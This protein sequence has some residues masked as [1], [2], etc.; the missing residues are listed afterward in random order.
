MK[1]K[2][3]ADLLLIFITIVWGFSIPLMRNTLS[4]IPNQTY[5]FYRFL[6]A[7]IIL[8]VIFR[9]K[10][11]KVSKLSIIR[12][13]IVGIFLAGT[14]LLTVYALSYTTASNVSFISGL[15]I[16]TVPVL[17][18]IFLKQRLNIRGL[19]GIFLA[20]FGLFL[21]SGGF[22]LSFNFGDFLA[23]LCAIFLTLQILFIDIYGKSEDPFVLG[24]IQI[25]TA[26]GIYFLVLCVSG[27]SY[28]FERGGLVLFTIILTGVI[29]TALAFVGQTY[30]QQFTSPLHVAIIFIL[31]PV[32]GAVFSSLLPNSQGIYEVLGKEEIIGGFVL[33]I[34][35]LIVV[36]DLNHSS[37]SKT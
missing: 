6:L 29:S 27:V 24:T 32:F 13:M 28:T 17:S 3:Y 23:L 31:E 33:V 25:Y 30:V 4:Y 37:V 1:K 11:R 5:L 34:A 18:S 36:M 35:M 8:T 20:S 9:K 12:G 19:L 21:I 22:E 26:T 15:N 2:I 16:I 10:L 14:L 7:S